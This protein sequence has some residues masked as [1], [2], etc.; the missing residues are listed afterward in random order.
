MLPSRCFYYINK[1]KRFLCIAQ[2][3]YFYQRFADALKVLDEPVAKEHFD[4]IAKC[5]D[6]RSDKERKKRSQAASKRRAKV[7]AQ[8]AKMQKDF[9]AENAELFENTSTEVSFLYNSRPVR[10]RVELAPN[11]T[12]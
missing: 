6:L 5:T 9:I 8:M 1:P 10:F 11:E 12:N 4:S 7:M 2:L 3:F